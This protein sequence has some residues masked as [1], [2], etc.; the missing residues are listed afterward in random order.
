[1]H[2]IQ[3][4]LVQVL[5]TLMQ[6][7]SSPGLLVYR[8]V[9]R[10]PPRRSY[11]PRRPSAAHPHM[12]GC[13]AGGNPPA[14]GRLQPPQ[15]RWLH[16]QLP[17]SL[18]GSAARSCPP[19]PPASFRPHLHA[20]FGFIWCRNVTACC[21]PCSPTYNSDIMHSF[22]SSNPNNEKSI[23]RRLYAKDLSVLQI[24]CLRSNGLLQGLQQHFSP[25]LWAICT[26]QGVQC[27]YVEPNLLE[28]SHHAQILR[29]RF[30][31]ILC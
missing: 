22:L 28:C 8:D 16:S 21:S 26:R 23:G 3:R 5:A 30:S 4:C 6:N 7:G 1:M 9:R 11:P 27:K 17:P 14:V 2:P 20:D 31:R 12:W 25:P 15:H 13:Q 29:T 24:K 19:P 10:N 18:Q